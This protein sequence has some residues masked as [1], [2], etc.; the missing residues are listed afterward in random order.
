MPENRLSAQSRVV[1]V[2]YHSVARCP[3]RFTVREYNFDMDERQ[4][5]EMKQL[6]VDK[7]EQYVSEYIVYCAIT[8]VLMGYLTVYV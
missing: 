4:R 3:H 7:R 5:L 2:D 6:G 1:C 8:V